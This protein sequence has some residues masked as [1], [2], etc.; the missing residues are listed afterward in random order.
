MSNFEDVLK[1]LKSQTLRVCVIGI[2]RI[3]LPTA[4]SFAKS[5]L[6]TVGVDIN[7]NLIQNINSG[8]FPLKDEPGYQEI[9]DN[10]IKNKKFS[11]TTNIEDVVPN[12][13][14]ILL[15]LPTPMDEN[16]IPDYS[17]LRTVASK[18]SDILS[19]NS[20]VI[21]ESTIEPGFIEDEM[22]SIITKSGRLTAEENFFI[23]VCPENANPGEILHDF[24]NLPRLVG[25]I[26]P[27]IAK[28]IKS[29]YNFVFSVELVE[30]PNCKTA[31]AVKLT[32]NVFRDI[33]I[34][35]V[36]ELSLMFE[37]LG[38]DTNKVLEA[39]KKKYNFQIHYPGAG[40][41]GPCL[42]INS[43]Q[44]LNTA[45][46]TG[47]KLDIIESGRKI[48]EKMPE[49]VIELTLDAFKESGKS[50]QGSDILILGISYKP[51]VKDIQ[52]TPAE[53]IIKK[54][55]DLGTNVHIY[56]PYFQSTEKFDI[57][58]SESMSPELLEKMDAAIIVTAHDEFTKF[59]ISNFSKMKTPI[60][61]D[62]RGIVDP[63]DAQNSKLIF[64]GLGRG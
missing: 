30:M 9:F 27:D 35:F 28:T 11:A 22:V 17:A 31:N 46:R 57:K 7:E 51:D 20:L 50:L 2:G 3:G 8:N 56:D 36:S 44:L 48:N 6:D 10:V 29:I 21:V 5:G 26:N 4:L 25:G 37:K 40:V 33:N 14:L 15:S 55:K 42:P 18:L 45:R 23:G 41:G 62:T 64:R 49:H 16:N 53:H 12:S 52:L 63:I 19:P 32:T 47:V 61:I 59:D 60:L 24:T 58:I 13:D 34:A 39:A 38:I 54:L 1:S 43:Y